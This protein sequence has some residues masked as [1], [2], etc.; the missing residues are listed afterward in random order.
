MILPKD[1]NYTSREWIA[2]RRGLEAEAAKALDRLCNPSCT[3]DEGHQLR[4]RILFIRGFL[5]EE[6]AAARPQ[7][8]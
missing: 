1:F 6:N 8:T 4:G 5:L 7:P 2:V 3:H